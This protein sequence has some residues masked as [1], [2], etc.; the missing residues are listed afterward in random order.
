MIYLL[1]SSLVIMAASLSGKVLVWKSAGTFIERNLELLVS[2]SAGVFLVFAWQL[3]GEAIAH[4]GALVGFIWVAV[5][6]AGISLVCRFLPHGTH[7]HAEEGHKRL[8]AH[9]LMISDSIHNIGDGILLAASFGLSSALGF[10]AVLSI[11]AH[12]VVQ[13][14]GEFFVL[15]DAGYSVN[16]ALKINFISSSTILVGAI[17][18]YILFDTFEA[19][20]GP[21]LGIAAGGVLTVVFYDLIPHSV[22]DAMR[23]INYSKHMLWFAAG[24]ILMNFITSLIP[25]ML[26]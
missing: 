1:L 15:R 13:E 9:R 6:I 10:T 11:F 14:I 24:F 8:D 7:V 12:E 23:R 17:G 16:R 26:H 25:D 4:N 20:E 2:F 3:S 19:L 22:R 18:G 21:L 5:G